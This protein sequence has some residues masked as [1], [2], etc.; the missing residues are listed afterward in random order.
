MNIVFTADI[1]I[2]LHQKNVP[3]D[4]AKNRYTNML[5]LM[6]IY[7]NSNNVD[8]LI[9]GGDIFDRL[10][11][12]EELHV[13]FDMLA[14]LNKSCPKL[15]VLIYSGNHEAVKKNTTFLSHL[16][17]VTSFVNNNA[18]IIDDFYNV[19]DYEII[20]YNKLKE[21]VDTKRK[22]TSKLCFTHVRGEIPPHV[23]PEVDLTYFDQWETVFAGDLHS[24]SNCQRNIVYPGSPVTTSFHRDTVDT[25]FIHIT[26]KGWDFIKMTLPQ[27]LRKTVTSVSEM[28]RTDYHHTIY[29]L[30]GDLQEMSKIASN[31]ELLDKKIVAKESVSSLALTPEMTMSQE[32]EQ[33][34]TTVLK[35][36]NNKAKTVVAKFNDYI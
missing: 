14:E 7:I 28:I 21:A 27:L 4:W 29:E 9:I 16:R 23:L 32:L 26:D 8:T 18:L 25:G 6:T 13:Y 1:H 24:H 20:P 5:Y 10:P 35:M 22:A 11:T 15:K 30:E 3:V 31:T 17:Y 12:L 36:D 33:Y 34:L 2:K 19:D